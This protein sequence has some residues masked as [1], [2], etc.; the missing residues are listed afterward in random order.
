MYRLTKE[1]YL[2]DVEQ[3]A[4]HQTLTKFKDREPRNT[5]L[6][7]LALHTGARAS[8]LLAL[9]PK[10]LDHHAESV[11]VSGLKGSD[12]REI[13]IPGWLFEMLTNLP[14]TNAQTLFGITYIRFYQIWC[15]YRPVK[16]KLHS[17][18]HSFAINL[19]RKTKDLRL[20]QVA[21]G[22]RNWNNTMIY[23]SYQYRTDELRKALIS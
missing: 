9:T 12:D 11:S 18:R 5:A 16:K 23:A 6:I 4:L 7:W 17:L 10:D 13:P 8:E 2:N 21:L 15:D 1:K 20:L 22:H 3:E 19:Y 14:V